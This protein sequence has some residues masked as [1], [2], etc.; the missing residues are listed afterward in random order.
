M[1]FEHEP[2]IYRESYHLTIDI[3]RFTK[4]CH[5]DFK[6]T[7]GTA[8]QNAVLEMNLNLYLINS[9]QEDTEKTL[10]KTIYKLYYVR[11]IM[12]SFID[13]SLMKMETSVSLNVRLENLLS[14][15]NNWKK[16]LQQKR[17]KA[18]ANV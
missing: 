11:M 10:A 2:P 12:R 18:G 1:D 4:D 13:M 17:Q 6:F 14:S 9:G 15:L 5:K 7:L 8:L 16:S 3:L